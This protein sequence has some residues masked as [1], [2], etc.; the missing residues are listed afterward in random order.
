MPYNRGDMSKEN[1]DEKTRDYQLK[2]Y[3][4]DK[5]YDIGGKIV[6]SATWIVLAFFA[7][8]SIA[9]LAGKTTFATFIVSIVRAGG[10]GV[11]VAVAGLAVIWAYAERRLRLSKVANLSGRIKYL[12][13]VIDQ[14]RSSSDLTPS[15]ENHPRDK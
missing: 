7:Y 12:E 4:A 14:N 1:V 5:R 13:T 11:W 8:R 2:L 3:L 6:K 15:G 10:T 9:V